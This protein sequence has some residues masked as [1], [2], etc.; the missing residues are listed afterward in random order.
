[1]NWCKIKHNWFRVPEPN[2]FGF[3]VRIC[4]R[5][6]TVQRFSGRSGSWFTITEYKEQYLASLPT[7]NNQPSTK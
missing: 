5:C 7:T 2:K 6:K 1:M 3:S 4:K